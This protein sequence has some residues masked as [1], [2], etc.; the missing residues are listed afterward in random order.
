MIVYSVEGDILN[1]VQEIDIKGEVNTLA[2]DPSGDKLA[3]SGS[4]KP[5]YIYETISYKVILVII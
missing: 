5:V 3:V 4:H 1:Q 2:Y